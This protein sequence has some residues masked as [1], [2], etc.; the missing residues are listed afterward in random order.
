MRV[1]ID[2]NMPARLAGA[3]RSLGHDVDTAPEEGLRGAEDPDL[4]QAAQAAKRFF[5]T[6]DLDFSD[7]RQFVPGRHFGILLI[8]LRTPGRNAVL[9]RAAEL[10]KSGDIES[11]TGCFVVASEKKVRVVTPINR[12]ESAEP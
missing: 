6:Q 5:V 11:W 7:V 9:D 12:E 2:E 10:F 4:W 8:R 1:K 3:L